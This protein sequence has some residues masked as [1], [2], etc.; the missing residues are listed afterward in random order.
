MKLLLA[1]VGNALALLATAA[2]VPGISF[3]GSWVTLLLAGL[4]FGL[5]NLIVRPIALFLAL[6]A[7]ILTLGLF[8][9]VLNGLLLWLAAAVVPGY[10]VSGFV[11]GLLGSLVVSVVSWA[12]HALTSSDQ[13]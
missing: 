4:V 1:I 5:F 11:P 2:L 9:F 3:T 6:P 10:H 8:Y 12:F 13:K 7:L